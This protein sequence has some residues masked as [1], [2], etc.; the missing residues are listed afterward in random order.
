[1]GRISGRDAEATRRLVLD[2]AARRFGSH[3][4]EASLD[5]IAELAGVS[6]GGLKYHFASKDAL[7]RALAEDQLLE[8]R[9]EVH[10]FI[11]EGDDGPG[12]LTRAYVAAT[13]D[14]LTNADAMLEKHA[15]MAQL[16]TVPVV[17]EACREDAAWWDAA[18]AADGTDPVTAALV[19]AA[20]DGLA[21]A[22]LWGAEY[23]PELLAQIGERLVDMTRA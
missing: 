13:L 19:V 10:S 4:I 21:A 12:R 14:A 8:F 20:A 17:R 7:L 22:P 9:A 3:G 6:K 2:A 16:S 11:R 15:L 18:I 5:S 23:A 1:M